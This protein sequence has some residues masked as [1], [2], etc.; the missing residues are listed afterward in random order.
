[1][2]VACERLYRIDTESLEIRPAKVEAR[3]LK[4]I[5]RDDATLLAG[6]SDGVVMW[7]S[8]EGDLVRAT[9]V[10]AGIG[11][12]D[13]AKSLAPL[14]DAK[15]VDSPSLRP[16]EIPAIVNIP[17]EHPRGF[18]SP[19][20]LRGDGCNPS[21]FGINVQTAGKYR[22]TIPLQNPKEQSTKFGTLRLFFDNELKGETK[23]TDPD[24]LNQVAEIELK[25]GVYDVCIMPNGWQVGML[26][27]DAKI[28]EVK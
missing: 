11:M 1:L 24:K 17:F 10:G 4:L 28:E 15:L 18:S 3:I 22:F 27:L 5:A 25:P 14:R 23:P 7:L 26:L 12:P 8:A 19:L 2:W 16:H 20:D 21:H 6:T 9:V 13:P